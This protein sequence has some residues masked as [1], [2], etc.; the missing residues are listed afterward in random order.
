[1][2]TLMWRFYVRLRFPDRQAVKHSYT[3][4]SSNRTV[5]VSSIPGN[6]ATEKDQPTWKHTQPSCHRI[7]IEEL[8]R[9]KIDLPA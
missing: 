6:V 2:F 8:A 3:P 1:M 7:P 9:S 5:I 4:T